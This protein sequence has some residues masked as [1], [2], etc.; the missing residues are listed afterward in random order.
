MADKPNTKRDTLVREI[1]GVN[2][3]LKQLIYLFLEIED[4]IIRGYLEDEMTRL[5]ELKRG[6]KCELVALES[7]HPTEFI[8]DVLDN[9]DLNRQLFEMGY[10]WG[11]Q[12]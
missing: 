9:R 2:M 4:N 11:I 6:F 7:S 10:P 12:I 1:M 3:I 5:K 8:D